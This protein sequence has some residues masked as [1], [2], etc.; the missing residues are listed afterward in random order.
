VSLRFGIRSSERSTD[1]SNDC[2]DFMTNFVDTVHDLSGVEHFIVHA[3]AAVLGGL[4]T[5][6]NRII[7]P[8]RYDEVHRL[9]DDFPTLGFTLNGGVVGLVQ[10][11]IQLTHSLKGH[12]LA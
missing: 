2:Y 3:R 9:A 10:A 4:S 1:D 7:P 12:A 11:E 8:L 6:A 5:N